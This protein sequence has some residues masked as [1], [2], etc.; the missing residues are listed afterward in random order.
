MS[1]GRREGEGDPVFD[2]FLEIISMNLLFKYKYKN[3]SEEMPRKAVTEIQNLKI[4]KANERMT[5]KYF[6]KYD[7]FISAKCTAFHLLWRLFL[8]IWWTRPM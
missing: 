2:Q 4:Q 6:M 8:A 3:R 5:R 1:H 7:R